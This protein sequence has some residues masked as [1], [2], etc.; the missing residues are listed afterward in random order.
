ENLKLPTED[1]VIL[2]ERACSVGTLS[3]LQNIDKELN[4][5]NQFLLEKSQEDEPKKTN[6]EAEVQS[7]A[8]VPIHQD[9]SSVPLMTTPVIDLTDP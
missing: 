4:F 9:T 1:Q 7:M 6:I 8:T 5:T 3:S 2:K